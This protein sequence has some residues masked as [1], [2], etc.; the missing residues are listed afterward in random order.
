MSGPY[1]SQPYDPS[2]W[3]SGWNN[4]PNNYQPNYGPPGNQYGQQY[5]NNAYPPQ[6]ASYASPPPPPS[7]G[8]P[9]QNYGQQYPQSQQ[10]PYPQQNS[11]N[12]LFPPDP[13]YRPHSQYPAPPPQQPSDPYRAPSPNPYP[14]P[15]PAPYR[16]PSPYQ[17][18]NNLPPPP[19]GPPGYSNPAARVPYSHSHHNSFSS[20]NVPFPVPVPSSSSS[21][22]DWQQQSQ[23]DRSL[24]SHSHHSHNHSYGRPPPLEPEEVAMYFSR[25]NC[26]PIIPEWQPLPPPVRVF[27]LSMTSSGTEVG[28]WLADMNGLEFHS[29][30][31][32]ERKQLSKKERKK[33]GS[34]L[35]GM[36]MSSHG[37]HFRDAKYHWKLY[38]AI[39]DSDCDRP[40]W[41]FKRKVELNGGKKNVELEGPGGREVSFKFEHG[42]PS[43]RGGY[44][45][46]E[47]T[48]P[49]GTIY[50][51]RTDRPISMLYG[52]RADFVRYALFRVHR[53]GALQLVA[54]DALWDGHKDEPGEAITIR[55]RGLDDAMVLA[56]VQVMKD[57]Q[58]EDVLRVER[59]KN[60]VEFIHAE[61]QA[62]D[63]KLGKL[64]FWR[65]EDF[66]DPE[67]Q[68]N[69]ANLTEQLTTAALGGG[70]A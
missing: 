34:M 50:E 25:N 21:G 1:P 30:P 38:D 69:V 6:P 36:K 2:A 63:T 37:G 32:R 48:A 42:D 40:L 46:M 22:Q 61:A 47:F 56:T 54:D 53:N 44:D 11:Q 13:G 51:W 41:C 62:R 64:S 31:W 17:Q 9:A 4:Q 57:M 45:K 59:N 27:Y 5:S 28:N 52:W 19:P 20:G 29:I 39:K 23:D 68:E 67:L 35:F 15:S 60:K 49:D 12:V 18:N 3:N 33:C 7:Y 14:Q 43:E 10:T 16:A 26:I 58:W 65:K 70:G 24:F 8:P 66:E 55:E